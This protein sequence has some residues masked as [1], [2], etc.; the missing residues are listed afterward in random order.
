MIN[1]INNYDDFCRISFSNELIYK[2]IK[3]ADII[4]RFIF[5]IKNTFK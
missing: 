3:L 5:I 1:K 4:I 2:F